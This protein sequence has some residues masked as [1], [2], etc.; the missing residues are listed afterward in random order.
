MIVMGR[1]ISQG[2]THMSTQDSKDVVTAFGQ[3]A[4]GEKNPADAAEQYMSEDYVQHNPQVPDGRDAFVQMVAGLLSQAPDAAFDV[5]RVIAEDDLV[6]LHTHLKMTP[7]E[8]GQAVV[9]IFRVEDGK[10]VEHWDVLQP[11]PDE[12]ANDNSM[13]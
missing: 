12:S 2:R 9:D 13:F 4:F 6:V 3:L 10:V 5:K 1:E 8:K 7:D 11:V